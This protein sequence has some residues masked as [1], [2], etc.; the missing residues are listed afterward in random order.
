M[1]KVI[2]LLWRDNRVDAEDF[3]RQLRTELA[4]RLVR[5]GAHNLQLNLDDADVRP[6][7][8]LR[9]EQAGELPHAVVSFWVDTAAGEFRRPYD[10]ALQAAC[11]RMAGYLV[12]ESVPI[13]NT[14]FPAQ[15]GQR[16][17]GFSQ[18]AF[19]Q[20]PP[21]LTHEAWLG[22]WQNHHMRVAIDTQDNFLYVQNLV[23]Q[24]LTPGA[25]PL[26]AIVEEGFPPA[27]MTDPMAFFD[28]PGDEAKFQHNL[29]VMMDSCQRFIDFDQLGVVLT[30]QY[31]L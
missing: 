5:L 10:E 15:A 21:R 24:V 31:P 27:A 11:A 1:Q 19:L 8:G 26:A 4:D 18:L 25:T 6:A 28:A 3:F 16:T 2:Y 29:A 22:I 20:L 7:D 12:C 13:R 17:H 9:Q 14:R 23:V 30:S